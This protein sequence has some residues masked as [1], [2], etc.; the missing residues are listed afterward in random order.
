MILQKGVDFLD[1]SFVLVS[2]LVAPV[3][4]FI[5]VKAAV[6]EAVYEALLN[7]YKY[8]MKKENHEKRE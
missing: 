2:Y 3:I 4:L 8:K 1:I 7:F 5:I 6:R